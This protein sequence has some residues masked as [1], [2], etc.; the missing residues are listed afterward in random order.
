M[1]IFSLTVTFVKPFFDVQLSNQSNL[2]FD[3]LNCIIL[4]GVYDGVCKRHTKRTASLGV[5]DV[6]G[7][8]VFPDNTG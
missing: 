4:V 5:I 1:I 2:F 3:R 6:S 7:D 8:G